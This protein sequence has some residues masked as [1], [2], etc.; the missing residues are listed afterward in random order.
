VQWL[1]FPDLQ[2]VVVDNAPVD[3]QARAI[4]LRHGAEYVIE[5]RLGLS[6]A[7]NT[8]ARYSSGDIVAYIDDD[9]IPAHDWPNEL[10]KAFD[11]DRTM[12]VA[13]ANCPWESFEREEP[14]VAQAVWRPERW[15]VD[16]SHPF[17]FEMAN[18]GGSGTEAIWLSTVLPLRYGRGSTTGLGWEQ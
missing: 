4:A 2:V 14:M 7:R 11:D 1:S 13:G 6:R 3:E 17:W 16:A 18:L 12:A 10:V 5:P 8:G 9:A 15:A